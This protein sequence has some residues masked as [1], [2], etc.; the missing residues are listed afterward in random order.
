MIGLIWLLDVAMN[1]LWLRSNVMVL[2]WDRPA[3]LVRSLEYFQLLQPF[4]PAAL[5]NAL[6]WDSFYPPLFHISASGFYA[7]FGVSATVA[8]LTNSVY[9][10][11]LLLATYGIGEHL[12]DTATGLLAACLVSLFPIVFF[13][14]RSTYIDFVLMSMV[15]L[16]I[17]LLLKTDRF[18][19]RRWSFAWGASLGFG[20]LAK[21]IFVVFV[22]LPCLYVLLTSPVIRDLRTVL[23]PVR[24]QWRRLGLALLI[25]LG[26]A[27]FCYVLSG[28]WTAKATFGLP[29]TLLYWLL[30]AGLVYA[31]SLPARP[32][33]NVVGAVAIALILAAIWYIPNSDFITTALYKAYLVGSET[34]SASSTAGLLPAWLYYVRGTVNEHLSVPIA[35]LAAGLVLAWL[36]QR[37][38]KWQPLAPSVWILGLWF[39]VPFAFFASFS[40]SSSWSMRFTISL[41]PPVALVLARG[42][43][44]LPGPRLRHWV[45]AI[46]LIVA[47]G[48][49]L[50]LSLDALAGLPDRT[51]LSLPGWGKLNWFA[52]GE[53]VQWPDSGLTDH[54]YWVMP[55][56]FRRI[57]DDRDP[58]LAQPSQVGILVNQPYFNGYH[59]TYAA[60]ADYPAIEAIDLRHER[61]G[62]PVYPQ[63]FNVDYLV[64]ADSGI[65][66]MNGSDQS[67]RLAT[68]ILTRPPQA[69]SQAFREIATYPV[70]S[71][72]VIHLFKNQSHQPPES[73]PPELMPAAMGTL[74]N[75]NLGDRLLL[76]HYKVD[77]AQLARNGK[78]VVELYWLGLQKMAEDYSVGLKVVN[79]D[80]QVWGKQEGRPAWGSF[81]T[82]TWAQ[83]EVVKDVREIPLLPGTPLGSYQIE[84]SV[85]DAHNQRELQ[86]IDGRSTLM[87]PVDVPRRLALSPEQ[88]DMQHAVG[89]EFGGKA[90]LLGYNIESGFRPGDNIHLT[91]FW[92]AL[93]PIDA[94][95]IVFSHLTGRD[96]K[97]WGQKD[98]PPAAGFYPTNAWSAGEIVRDQ[99]DIQISPEAP[100]GTYTLEAGMYLPATGARLPVAMP[101]NGP[102]DD[103]VKLE[104]IQIGR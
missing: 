38:R 54:R 76:T 36:V 43:L 83:G 27:A 39:V 81:P 68:A 41:L 77:P 14:S 100:P 45:V 57:M 80:Y 25:G 10:A 86:P 7:A 88:L 2:G 69:F 75:F 97:T 58:T 21:W 56:L 26:G 104:T 72:D 28:D 98:N 87:G 12:Y 23:G 33:N 8:A 60:K 64:A 92:Q 30:T 35:L 91:L 19:N 3:H 17:F 62:L 40:N 13:M 48:Q 46:L 74:A 89:K 50:V 29:L 47:V 24:I 73:I 1:F 95:Y 11:I 85:Y 93:Q 70:P 90:R 79:G 34:K 55:S 37:L 49:W 9:L 103:K 20:L 32:L 53:F 5:L 6:T 101:G 44:R 96:G 59:A 16:S 84:L 15:A 61:K 78:L 94:S 31:S 71:G 102:E 42:C 82:Q 63:I 4:S 18:Q 99:Y 52:Q 67:I 66:D 65:E 51:A 22:G